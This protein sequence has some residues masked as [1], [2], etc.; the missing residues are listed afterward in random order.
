MYGQELKVEVTATDEEEGD[1]TK[2]IKEIENT[3]KTDTIGIYKIIYQV[4]IA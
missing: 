2:E 3:V 4:N 1:L